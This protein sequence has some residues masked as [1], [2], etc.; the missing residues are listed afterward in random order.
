MPPALAPGSVPG[1]TVRNEL[2]G[3]FQRLRTGRGRAI[4]H[5]DQGRQ[6]DPLARAREAPML[7]DEPSAELRRM[8]EI[9]GLVEFTVGD[10]EQVD[11]RVALASDQG[12]QNAFLLD[13]ARRPPSGLTAHCAN[14]VDTDAVVLAAH[15]GLPP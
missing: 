3:S 12:P 8:A 13:P 6:L 1:K 9:V 10:P 11:Q 5:G 4:E 14:A 7:G 2:L 15:D